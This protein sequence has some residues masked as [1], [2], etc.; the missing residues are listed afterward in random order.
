MGRHS[1]QQQDRLEDLFSDP[2]N[3]SV[4]DARIDY[5]E[6]QDLSS[7]P[8]SSQTTDE[9]K[10]KKKGAGWFSR[11]L[12]VFGELLITVGLLIG[13]FIVWQL[14]WTNVEATA[15]IN[16]EV[17]KLHD[18]FGEV[19]QKIGQPQ[20][21]EPPIISPNKTEGAPLAV[22][23]IPAFGYDHATPIKEGVSKKVLDSGA[24]G[25]YPKTALPG[26]VG[27]FSTAVHREVYG[28]RMLHVDTLETGTPIVVETPDAWLVYKMVGYEIVDPS[29]GHV[30]LPDPFVAGEAVKNGRNIPDTKPTRRLLTI[31]TCHPPMVSN[32]RWIVHAEFDHWV[33][34][35]DGMPQELVDPDEQ[36][37]K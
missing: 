5:A 28:A 32:K 13:L 26:E 24:F 25:H 29:D 17:S 9:E 18:D 31:T 4:D 15:S 2:Q 8:S 19:P 14:W 27:N 21:G 1:D 7:S 22:M 16:S 35:S 36:A 20:S 11:I 33:K 30:I 12:G 34:R 3:H 23:H 6:P 10:K 37:N